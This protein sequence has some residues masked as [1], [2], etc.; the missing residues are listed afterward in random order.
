[1]P[2]GKAVKFNLNN[3]KRYFLGKSSPA[4]TGHITWCRVNADLS[5]EL[6]RVRS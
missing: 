4:K 2:C 6:D 5:V 3:L 1:M